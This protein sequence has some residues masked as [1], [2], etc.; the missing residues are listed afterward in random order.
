MSLFTEEAMTF[1]KDVMRNPNT[2]SVW[3]L[4]AT[5]SVVRP[6]SD[7]QVYY[8]AVVLALPERGL[9]ALPIFEVITDRHNVGNI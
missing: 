5:G 3:H 2:I 7:R 4:D 8:Y 1:A 6:V 9:P